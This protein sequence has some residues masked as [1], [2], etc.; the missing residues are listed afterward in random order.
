MT[1]EVLRL[2][3][4]RY[5]DVETAIKDQAR[6]TMRQDNDWVQMDSTILLPTFTSDHEAERDE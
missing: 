4:Y 5:A 6:W 1:V 3:R 2:I